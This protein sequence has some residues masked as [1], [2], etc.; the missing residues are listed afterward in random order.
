MVISSFD[1]GYTCL[2]LFFADVTEVLFLICRY[3]STVQSLP[4][5]SNSEMAEYLRETAQVCAQS[6]ANKEGLGAESASDHSY[7]ASMVNID[8][9]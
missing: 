6:I 1:K 2:L 5:L 3:Y 8:A 7:P 4:K 9:D